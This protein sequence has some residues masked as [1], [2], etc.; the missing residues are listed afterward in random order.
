M[1]TSGADKNKLS[2]IAQR[3]EKLLASGDPDPAEAQNLVKELHAEVGTEGLRDIW[4]S[5]S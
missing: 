5:G 2:N 4:K 1:A 3:A